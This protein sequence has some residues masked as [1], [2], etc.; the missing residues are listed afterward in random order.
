[1]HVHEWGRRDDVPV[2]FWH[3]AASLPE[4]RAVAPVLAAAGFHVLALPA[5]Q[6][7]VAPLVDLLHELLD[8]R[9]LDRPVLVGR[10]RCGA[11]A[12][13]YAAAHPE[14]VRALVLLDDG[15]LDDGAAWSAVAAHEIPTL[16]L[17]VAG[18][19]P[20]ARVPH[21]EVRQVAGAHLGEEIAAWLV[22]QGL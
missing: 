8:V 22:D 18:S 3:T 17:V 9:E 11:V 4:L 7:E 10:S 13:G 15:H 2:V 16:L 6:V 21:G 1:M 12:L 5:E 19:A 14:D 20:A